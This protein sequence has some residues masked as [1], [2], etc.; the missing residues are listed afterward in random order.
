MNDLA[1]KAIAIVLSGTSEKNFF[2]KSGELRYPLFLDKYFRALEGL[3][4]DDFYFPK[5]ERITHLCLV[6]GIIRPDETEITRIG[7][8]IEKD[9]LFPIGETSDMLAERMDDFFK[10]VW[11]TEWAID[12]PTRDEILALLAPQPKQLSL[13]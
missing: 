11:E 6:M 8:H 1:K 10:N 13:F 5:L 4:L 3:W 9:R 7:Y 2:D 12:P